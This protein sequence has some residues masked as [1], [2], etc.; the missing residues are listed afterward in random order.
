M[1]QLIVLTPDDLKSL[2][3]GKI[4]DCGEDMQIMCDLSIQDATKRL[5]ESEGVNDNN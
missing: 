4:L 1:V 5:T 2:E 3:Q